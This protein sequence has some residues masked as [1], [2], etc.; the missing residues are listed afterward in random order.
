MREKERVLFREKSFFLGKKGV[1]VFFGEKRIFQG[2]KSVF[3]GEKG[4]IWGAK[5][6]HILGKKRGLFWGEKIGLF[7]WGKKKTFL[8]KKRAFFG[9][10]RGHF[11]G[12][13]RAFWG[14]HLLL[15]LLAV[16]VAHHGLGAGAAAGA[17]AALEPLLRLL[18]APQF[19]FHLH[20]PGCWGGGGQKGGATVTP[21][22]WRGFSQSPPVPPSSRSPRPRCPGAGCGQRALPPGT[23]P[24]PCHREGGGFGAVP[25]P[26]TPQT[27]W[28][29]LTL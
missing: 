29:A 23:P 19:D 9:E 11:F 8:G 28:G 4:H 18:L 17:P 22:P 24:R 14:P 15:L 7:F 2:E 13:K 3:F 20:G 6:G 27:P 25:P 26:L 10:K 12:E 16:V 5:K 1:L 21:G